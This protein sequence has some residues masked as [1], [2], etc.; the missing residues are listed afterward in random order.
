[1]PSKSKYKIIKVFSLLEKSIELKKFIK[2]NILN[3][4]KETNNIRDKKFK[5]KPRKVFKLKSILII[6]SKIILRIVDINL[7]KLRFK[8]EF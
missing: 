5:I 6:F 1:M 4:Q 3:I 7:M 2:N 8:N